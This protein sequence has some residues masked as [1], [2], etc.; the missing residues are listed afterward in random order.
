MAK[1]GEEC[2][3]RFQERRHKQA[4]RVFCPALSPQGW[5]PPPAVSPSASSCHRSTR[6][7]PTARMAGR[8]D[9][10]RPNIRRGTARHQRR[11][12]ADSD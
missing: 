8:R 12:F 6:A 11:T 1:G 9:R 10:W 4:F 3:A 5:P 7:G 2:G